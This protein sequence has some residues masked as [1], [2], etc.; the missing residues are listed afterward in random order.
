MFEF[1]GGGEGFGLSRAQS[2][3]FLR[4]RGELQVRL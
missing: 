3:A 1:G 4:L 2:L